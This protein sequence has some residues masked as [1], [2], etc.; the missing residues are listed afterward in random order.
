MPLST[1][2]AMF[3]SVSYLQKNLGQIIFSIFGFLH[4]T[5]APLC[6]NVYV[7]HSTESKR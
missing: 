6:G 2:F 1:Q 4:F 3:H 5:N 7:R